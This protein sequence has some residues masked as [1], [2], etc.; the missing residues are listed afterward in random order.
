MRRVLLITLLIVVAA[1]CAVGVTQ[2]ANA[3][4]HGHCISAD[5]GVIGVASADRLL[6]GVLVALAFAWIVRRTMHD[7]VRTTDAWIHWW[8]HL[9]L[10]AWIPLPVLL[11][12]QAIDD[13]Q[14][15]APTFRAVPWRRA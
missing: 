9:F 10:R 13:P 1:T 6:L 7:V 12:S 4:D 15:Y 11:A 14:I 5:Q 2:T 8:R 3:A